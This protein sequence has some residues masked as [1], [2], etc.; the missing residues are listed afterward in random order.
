MIGIKKP[1]LS[2]GISNVTKRYKVNLTQSAQ[3]DL[4]HIYSYIAADSVN[5]ANQ[6]VLELEEQIYSLEIFP[7]RYPFIP[8]NDFFETD[9]RHLNYKKYR[10]IYR[11]SQNIVYILRIIKGSKLLDI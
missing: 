11:I 1:D 9:Y 2:F 10:L 5:N 4:E 7:E 6:F 8:E 3:N